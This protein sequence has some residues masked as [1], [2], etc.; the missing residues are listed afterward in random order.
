MIHSLNSVYG[1]C[2]DWG[3]G[4]AE[5]GDGVRKG[6]VSHGRNSGFVLNYMGSHQRSWESNLSLLSLTQ[7]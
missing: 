7:F 6:L 2:W 1:A 4:E 3:Q 5:Y